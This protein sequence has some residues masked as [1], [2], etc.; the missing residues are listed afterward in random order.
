LTVLSDRLP[1]RSVKIFCF[2]S[3]YLIEQISFNKNIRGHK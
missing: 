2:D 1:P 3:G